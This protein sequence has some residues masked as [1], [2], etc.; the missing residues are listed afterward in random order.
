MLR[1]FVLLLLSVL[2]C[3]EM[4]SAEEADSLS[5]WNQQFT[6]KLPRIVCHRGFYRFPGACPNSRASLKNAICLG[7]EGSEMDIWLTDDNQIIVNH[8]GK[9]EGIEI[10]HARYRNIKN[11]KLENGEKLPTLRDFLKILKKSRYTHL[12]VEVK[13]HAT[14]ERTIEAAL[15]GMKAVNDAGLKGMAEY[16]SFSL[17]A[18]AALAKMDAEAKVYY[19]GGDKTPDELHA[20]GIS[21]LNYKADVFRKHPNWIPRAHELGMTVTARGLNKPTDVEEMIKAGVDNMASD[22]PVQAMKIRQRMCKD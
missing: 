5:I 17:P 22:Y 3:W 16:M 4:L 21:S 19:L 18:C 11:M 7:A 8:D 1:R 15:A 2:S 14:R 13:R 12:F 20:L 10:Q 9:R 6:V